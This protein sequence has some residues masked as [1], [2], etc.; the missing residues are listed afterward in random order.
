[1]VKILLIAFFKWKSDAAVYQLEGTRAEDSTFSIPTLE[2]TFQNPF[3]KQSV[4]SQLLDR[5]SQILTL[6]F[7]EMSITFNE[8]TTSV[9][10]C[11]FYFWKK[12]SNFFPF[13]NICDDMTWDLWVGSIC[14]HYRCAS[15][16]G[17]QSCFHLQW[18][19]EPVPGNSLAI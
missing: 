18:R 1:M 12:S 17:P 10:T 4:V 6:T 5:S 7:Q 15:L 8:H 2:N 14:N 11:R 9:L 16:K 19:I 3:L 13:H